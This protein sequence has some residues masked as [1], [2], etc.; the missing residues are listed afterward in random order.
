M[1]Y[2]TLFGT[3]K[4]ILKEYGVGFGLLALGLAGG[5]LIYWNLNRRGWSSIVD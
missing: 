2:C 4:I 3:G 1:I 5:A